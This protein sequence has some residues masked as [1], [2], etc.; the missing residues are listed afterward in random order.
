VNDY[1]HLLTTFTFALM[2]SIDTKK[3][4]Y[5][6]PFTEA[7]QKSVSAMLNLLNTKSKS[8]QPRPAV[9]QELV[10]HFHDFIK[11]FLM[12]RDGPAALKSSKFASVLECFMAVFAIQRGGILCKAERLTTVC[13]SIKFWMR[14][15]IAFEANQLS[16]EGN[17][18]PFHE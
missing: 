5:R 18:P 13:A 3:T 15:C 2:M 14:L 4:P 11:P 9:V 17:S 6:F 10:P 8:Q 16:M 7:E 1:A 12:K